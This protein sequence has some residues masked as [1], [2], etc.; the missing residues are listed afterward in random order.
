MRR[1]RNTS[2][3]PPSPA[4]VWRAPSTSRVLADSGQLP[5]PCALDALG[6]EKPGALFANDSGAVPTPEQVAALGLRAWFYCETCAEYRP[7]PKGYGSPSYCGGTG[8]G[9]TASDATGRA[10]CYRCCGERDKRDM[11]TDGRTV[12]Y[13]TRK[14]DAPS[15]KERGE[16]WHADSNTGR[17]GYG[18]VRTS[19]RAQDWRVSNWPGS[20]TLPVL[21]IKRGE[22][23]WRN[24]DRVDVWFVF[25]GFVWHGVRLGDMD[26][27]RCKRT[28][29]E[30]RDKG[31]GRG[32]GMHTP[33]KSRALT[34][35]QKLDR[36]R[37]EVVRLELQHAPDAEQ[38]RARRK[39]ATLE[40]RSA[41]AGVLRGIN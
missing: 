11:R 34:H 30:W 4:L 38:A 26:L 21:G 3:N 18:R 19:L 2:N 1:Q 22:H 16:H 37:G 40:A 10:L 6:D 25:E 15:A 27:I 9:Y 33:R 14:P 23:N 20:L 31:N 5:E 28:R 12:L 8:Y 36:A 29:T 39:L 32:Y 35:A 17:G 41:T 7:T 24:V 13:L